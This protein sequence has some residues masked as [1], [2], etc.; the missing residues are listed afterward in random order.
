MDE[1]NQKVKLDGS[2]II[3]KDVLID[4]LNTYKILKDINEKSREDFIKKA[5]IIGQ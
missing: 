2:K 5:I 1:K 4:D 3:I